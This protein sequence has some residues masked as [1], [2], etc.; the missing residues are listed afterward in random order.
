MQF[1]TL[2]KLTIC[3][4]LLCSITTCYAT[5]GVKK[6]ILVGSP[7]CQ[8]PAILLCFLDS[9]KAQLRENYTLD[10][11]FVDDNK[12]DASKAFLQAFEPLEGET[13][14]IVLGEEVQK[15]EQ[16]S[17]Y[18]CSEVTHHWNNALVWKV[19]TFKDSIIRYAL[20]KNYDY[21]FLIDSDIVLHPK[22]IDQ[23]IKAQK[24]IISNIFWTKWQP[25]LPELPQVWLLDQYTLYHHEINETPSEGD[26]DIRRATFLEKLRIPG[27]YEV[28]G[29]GACTLISKRALEGG[30]SFQRI[31]NIT[32]WGEDRHFCVRA[33]ALGFDLFV[34][35]HYPAYHIYRESELAGVE[36][37]VKQNGK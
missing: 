4:L 30:I 22:T 28:G 29:L 13:V 24:D 15:G 6:R 5:D 11:Y 23:L 2:R 36:S 12:N 20:D 27:V 10:Y 37:F 35:T 8:H 32:F 25:Q 18:I 17:E 14:K 33:Q 7:V 21:L 9:L 16:K 31:K 3:L 1:G 34:D 26:I 19:A